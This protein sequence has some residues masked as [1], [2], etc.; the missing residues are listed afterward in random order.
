MPSEESA[1][2][3]ERSTSPGIAVE[4]K[5]SKPSSNA[6]TVRLP[7]LIKLGVGG[8]DCSRAPFASQRACEASIIIDGNIKRVHFIPSVFLSS[9]IGRG[10]TSQPVSPKR[11]AAKKPANEPTCPEFPANCPWDSHHSDAAGFPTIRADSKVFGENRI[12]CTSKTLL[13]LRLVRQ[14]SAA[15]CTI[16]DSQH[17]ITS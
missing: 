6:S 5:A 10:P 15:L 2:T 8:A 12:Q 9:I 13:L 16:Y 3:S 1:S 11:S 17:R 14:N 4:R 7:P